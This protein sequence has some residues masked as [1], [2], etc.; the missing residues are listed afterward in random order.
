MI[1]NQNTEF[2]QIWKDDFLKSICAFA[3]AQGGTLYIGLDDDGN[4]VGINNHKKLLE[5]LPNK[6]RDILG[7]VTQINHKKEN[8]KNFLEIVVKPYNNPVSFRGHFYYRSGSTIQD[9]N[10]PALEKFLLD[11]KGKKWDGVLTD[12][13]TI[14]DLS[15][16]AFDIFRKKAQRSKRIPE[17]DLSESNEKLLGLLGLTEENKLTRAAVLAF[18]EN[19]EKL[20]TG[21]YVK[22]GFFRTHSDLLYHDEIHG[23]LFEQIEK[24]MDIL[25][26]K[27]LRANIAYEGLTRTET[28]DYPEDALREALLNALI[29][30]DYPSGVPVQISV[31][32]N[33]LW[34]SN[35]GNL[36]KGWT[37]ENL[38][39]KH[40]SIPANPDIAKTFFRAGYIEHWGRGTVNIINYCKNAGLPVPD[41][42]FSAGLTVLFKKENKTFEELSSFGVN[43]VEKDT[44]KPLSKNDFDTILRDKYGI[45]AGYLRD[46]YGIR[47]KDVFMLID[48]NPSTSLPEIAKE[49]NVSLSTIEK[50]FNKL[51]KENLIERFGSKKTGYW[52]IIV[53]D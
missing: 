26:T 30:K 15:N 11:K 35:T 4:I 41:F 44:I 16:E 40:K 47:I 37:V 1:E 34:I 25:L 38:I 23:S 50:L 13:F 22:I 48:E 12:T 32:A 20:V 7:V 36:P 29:H 21:A 6:M 18:S 24:T 33:M 43:D 45:N 3:N 5:D 51:K 14:K 27:Y 52:K 19:P 17:E 10:G 53:N 42:N 28:Y 31:Y 8:D 2:K 46:K 49:L 9:L 39:T